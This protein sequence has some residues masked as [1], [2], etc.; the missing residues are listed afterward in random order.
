M[1]KEE[2]VYKPFSIKNFVIYSIIII[3][4]G[5]QFGDTVASITDLDSLFTRYLPMVIYASIGTFFVTKSL[6]KKEYKSEEETVKEKMIFGPIIVAVVLLCFGLYSVNSNV[7]KFIN[8]QSPENNNYIYSSL[9]SS[10]RKKLQEEFD[11]MIEEAK[12]EAIMNW[13]ITTIV[14]VTVAELTIVALRRKVGI[15]LLEGSPDT[16]NYDKTI[17]DAFYEGTIPPQK[18]KKKEEE[19][20]EI[21]DNNEEEK[22]PK[23]R[24]TDDYSP[25]EENSIKNTMKD[26]KW[27]L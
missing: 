22:K 3:Y 26:I 24:Y 4:I 18:D 13:M 10:A 23:R 1:K 5:I 8:E 12:S 7:K 25:D 11:R 2:K 15:W 9:S 20:D 17:K 16:V 6:A 19:D 14:Y 27:N 21:K